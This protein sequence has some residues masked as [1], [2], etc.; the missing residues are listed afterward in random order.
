[1]VEQSARARNVWVIVLSLV[2]AGVLAIVPLPVWLELWRPDWVALVLVYW[3]IA[4]PHRIG[5][6]TAWVVGFLLDVLEGNLLGLNSMVLTA[7]AYVA[8]TLYQRLR[9]FTP[10]Q[11]SMIML[12]LIGSGQLF[13]FWVQAATGR[14]TAD[15]LMFIMSALTSALL[16]P[17]VFVSLRF[18]RRSFRV[19]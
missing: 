3:V 18:W 12:L 19:N 2:F 5:L 13:I 8:L 17:L 9:M 4:L 11:Q 15:N 10:L 7:M 14:N 1:M 16:W 6:F